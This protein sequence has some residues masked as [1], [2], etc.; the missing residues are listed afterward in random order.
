MALL[1][2]FSF[3]FLFMN[4]F[5]GF[6]I[7]NWLAKM[8]IIPALLSVNLFVLIFWLMVT[9]L[10]GRIYCSLACPLGIS[11]DIFSHLRKGKK[12][13]NYEPANNKLRYV[14]L[15]AY[16]ASLSLGIHAVFTLLSPYAIFARFA[17]NVVNPLSVILTRLLVG[18][19]MV[20]NFAFMHLDKLTVEFFSYGLLSLSLS[21]IIMLVILVVAHLKG[22]WYCNN[23]CPVGTLLGLISF[24]S[25]QRIFI[26]VDK[27]VKCG[28]CERKCKASCIDSSNYTVDNSRCIVCFNCL[29]GCPKEAIHFGKLKK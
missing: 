9:W 27:C 1:V 24:R 11:Q 28:N 29:D 22:R 20:S 13:F 25:R 8:Q 6:S 10:W 26:E 17:A 16:I 15:I 4:F 14:I 3:I 18:G 2:W 7:L 19:G 5:Q 21:V 23:I 12:S